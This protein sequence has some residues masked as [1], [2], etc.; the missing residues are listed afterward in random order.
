RS[1]SERHPAH[2]P[3]I[4]PNTTKPDLRLFQASGF[5]AYQPD[6][7]G[8]RRGCRLGSFIEELGIFEP[9]VGYFPCGRIGCALEAAKE[10]IGTSGVA[11]NAANLFNLEQY[12]V[13]IAIKTNLADD[14]VVARF[15]ALAP[16]FAART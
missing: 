6:G 2:G 11:G 7:R 12:D 3:A 9:G 15:L 10:T 16:Q 1:S 14:L 4:W 5:R 8:C 13:A